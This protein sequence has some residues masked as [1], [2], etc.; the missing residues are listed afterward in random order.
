METQPRSE[1]PNVP[2]VQ[3]PKCG[4]WAS[5]VKDGRAS[6]D[7]YKRKRVCEACGRAFFTVEKAA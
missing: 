7:G 5:K 1:R 4:A 3:C 2:K 6:R